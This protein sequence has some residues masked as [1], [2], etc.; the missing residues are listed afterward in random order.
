M[1][2][3]RESE[4][5]RIGTAVRQA[6]AGRSSVLLVTGPLGIGRSSLLDEAG[7]P[8]PDNLRV[9]RANAAPTEQD[10]A[11]GI[12]HQLLG[13]LLPDGLPVPGD[14]DVPVS[15]AVLHGLR[16][17]LAEACATTPVLLLV[18]DLQW[19]DLPSLR[20]LAYLTRRT[21][22]MRV[23]L[24]CTLR[25]GEAR[26]Q[27]PLVGDLADAADI[28]RPAPLSLDG[29][30]ALIH[31]QLGEPAEDS[32]ALACHDAFAGNPLFLQS[33]LRD[34]ALNGHRPTA[35]Q[36]DQAR[37]LCPTQLRDRLTSC[38]H[39]Q[40]APVRDLAAAIAAFGDHGEPELV[41]RHARLDTIGYQRA[42]RTLNRLG[43][44]APRDDTPRF[45]HD[46]VCHA[47][48]SALTIAER[49]RSR[50]AAAEILHQ[51]GR[52][53]EH[54]A[55]LL[56][57]V[58][59]TRRP[60]A[61]GVLRTAADAAL[62]RSAP[63]AA[64]RYLRRA[65][66]ESTAG[67]GER[68]RLLI[69]LAKAERGIDPAACERHISQAVRLLSSATERA[70]A[71]L[72]IPPGF[73]GDATSSAVDLLR[74]VSEDFEPT[75]PS[76]RC[77][78][79]IALRLEARLWQAGHENPAELTGAVERLRSLA[80]PP[81][82]D[83]GGARELAAVL[84]NAGVLSSALPAPEVA[85]L[86]GQ[87]LER[88]PVTSEP[89][90][91]A[92]PLVAVALYAADAV[93]G[94]NTRL[95]CEQRTERPHAGVH[96]ENALIQLACGRLTQAREQADRAAGL[97]DA[98][99]RVPTTVVRAAVA[100]ESGNIQL[101][102]RLLEDPG[103]CWPASLAM[104]AVRQLLRASLVA[105]RGR[106]AA[107][108][109]A[110]LACGRQLESAGWRNSVLFPWR[111]RAIVLH[112]RLGETL[113]ALALAKEELVWARQW[114]APAALGRALRLNALLP[115]GGGESAL[116]E[117]AEILRT[118][119]NTLELARTLLQLG[120]TLEN[121]KEARAVLR[122]AV[123]LTTACGA[124]WLTERARAALG[125]AAPSQEAPLTQGER[126]VVS[127]VSRRLTNQEIAD[128]LGVSTRAV[129][130]HLT[131]C[132]RKLGVSGRRELLAGQSALGSH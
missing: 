98:D 128:E 65:L 73:L 72:L 110:L 29:T 96:A 106:S 52:P 126:K 99:W 131:S 55:D 85:A 103:R 20:W 50:D 57:G 108:L 26:A 125:T 9:L 94:I 61:M 62:C 74:N 49:E 116:R 35:E 10:F 102:E 83:T 123:D 81:P 77:P 2:L 23:A 80:T 11:F 56:M 27:H 109:K 105:R 84:N 92:L 34:Q 8:P 30:R 42:L 129:E 47:V 121:G 124:P 13:P 41:R 67:D 69:D 28:L 100:M 66:L 87:I 60:W 40:P 33:V 14:Q 132:Y 22:G 37:A 88:E 17:I 63:D 70:A 3:E 78:S 4:L 119:A 15:E 1:L 115:G 12:V 89:A 7:T 64:V 91:I 25:D 97:S 6:Q 48:D 54:V 93:E 19:V 112:H 5:A 39:T 120:R 79:D 71:T 18:D 75:E 130:K 82:L 24:V 32:Y 111:P 31:H 53:A 104:T 114:A 122:E 118:S 16:S 117:S 46:V 59:D 38:L 44:L 58:I 113:P 51:A 95:S 86:A 101:I 127:L 45:V 90:R 43:L 76:Q 21:D 107:A 68:A 36:A